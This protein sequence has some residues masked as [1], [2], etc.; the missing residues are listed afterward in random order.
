MAAA[1][2]ISILQYRLDLEAHRVSANQGRKQL[3][4]MD[5]YRLMFANTRIPGSPSDGDFFAHYSMQSS[6]HI[7]VTCCGRLYRVQVMRRLHETSVSSEPAIVAME[8]LA[9][10][11][12]WVVQDV[13]LLPRT[14]ITGCAGGAQKRAQLTHQFASARPCPPKGPQR[15]AR[16]LASRR[17]HPYY[18]GPRFVV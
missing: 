8:D 3:M 11:F 7:A 1:W 9:A 13:R 6:M 12:A 14:F 4:C 18:N 10:A 15:C 16:Q 17:G 5:Q 2:T